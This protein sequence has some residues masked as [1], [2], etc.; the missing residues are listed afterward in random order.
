MV[1]QYY[2][3]M[4]VEG[5]HA[6]SQNVEDWIQVKTEKK[7]KKRKRIPREQIEELGNFLN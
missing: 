6:H 2:N 3:I 7:E 4:V 1:Y 5:V